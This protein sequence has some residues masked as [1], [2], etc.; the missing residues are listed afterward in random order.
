VASVSDIDAALRRAV[1][2]GEVPGVVALAA[3]DRGILYEGA[4]GQRD[5]GAGPEM[6]LDT[7]FRIASMT[8]AVTSVAAMQLV[9]EGKLALDEPIGRIL[10]ELAAPYVLQGFDAA[11]K[12]R[13]RPAKRPVTLRH[14]LTHTAG[15]GYE[16]LSSELIRYIAATHTPSTSTGELASLRL[17][18][19]FDPGE[20]W[21][22]GIN[23]DWVGRAVENASGE[24]LDHY[25]RD[26]IFD[27]LGMRDSGFQLSAAQRERLVQVHRRKADGSLEPIAIDMPPSCPE[28]WSGGGALYSTGPDYL[29]FLR[30]LLGGGRIGSTQLL[31]PETVAQM[32]QNQVG[33]LA[34]GAM[35][36]M[37]PERTNDFVLFPEGECRWGL[38]Y[39]INTLPGPNGRAA[40]S[41]SWGGIFNSYYWID[42]AKCVA[43]VLLTQ[44]LPFADPSALALYG[45]FER[46]TYALLGSR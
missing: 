45:A 37:M 4:F 10:P 7:I 18:L 43:A 21:Q 44:L 32:G 39:M 24:P 31:R 42:P 19:L 5:I 34:A 1:E 14:L 38:A 40:G 29:A 15:F 27:P 2:A 30:M 36:T 20:K 25:F 26:H 46:E 28:F 22:Y 6:A 11:G 9:E 16:M 13:L 35:R 12:P 33:D 17:P 41:L 23:T 3:T 8:K